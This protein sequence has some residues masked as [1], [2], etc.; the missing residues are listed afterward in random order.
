[1]T[2][3]P[4]GDGLLDR[5]AERRGVG[6][7]D[8]QSGRLLVHGGVDELAHRDHVEGFGRAVVDLHVHVLAGGRDAVLHHRPEG[9]LAWPWLTTMMRALLLG[10]AGRGGGERQQRAAAAAKPVT[11][12]FIGFPPISR[13][14]CEKI[15]AGDRRS[16]ASDGSISGRPGTPAGDRCGVAASVEVAGGHPRPDADRTR[17]RHLEGSLCAAELP[18]RMTD[19][20]FAWWNFYSIF[21]RSVK[22]S[23]QA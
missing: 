17:W 13:V 19:L 14:S 8:D 1:M 11:S 16:A 7:R 20:L 23:V 6:D 18:N 12:D 3:M 5:G 10:E 21:S 15:S 2:G 4:G 9:S 22:G